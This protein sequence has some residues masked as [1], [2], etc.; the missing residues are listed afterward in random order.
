MND[1]SFVRMPIAE[2]STGDP[3]QTWHRTSK[4]LREINGFSGVEHVH[5]TFPLARHLLLHGFSKTVKN[6]SKTNDPRH[7]GKGILRSPGP[8]PPRVTAHTLT[9]CQRNKVAQNHPRHRQ[10]V[11]NP[12]ASGTVYGKRGQNIS[13]SLW[14]NLLTCVTRHRWHRIRLTWP[15]KCSM[16]MKLDVQC[17]S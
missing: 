3:L 4:N 5:V 10:T 1:S 14:K 8:A 2:V 15:L 6:L 11:R 12:Y 13:V 9:R 17:G 7:S 16:Y